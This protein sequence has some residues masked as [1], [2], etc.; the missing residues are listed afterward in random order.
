MKKQELISILKKEGNKH[1]FKYLWYEC[2]MLRKI[3]NTDLDN[4]RDYDMFNRCGYIRLKKK[5]L[6]LDVRDL[7]IHWGIT[8][9]WKIFDIEEWE[10]IQIE[11]DYIGFDCAHFNDIWST[12]TLGQKC[13]KDN[14]Y[15]NKDF[16]I[17]ELKNLVKQI[18][19]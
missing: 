2:V 19:K 3:T 12:W 5:D 8:W 6:N 18:K 4:L 11:G 13:F 16:V 10:A 15:K 1:I 14:I 17:N 9:E 7:D